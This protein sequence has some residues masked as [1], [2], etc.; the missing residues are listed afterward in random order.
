MNKEKGILVIISGFSGAG[1]GTIVSGLMDNYPEELALSISATT[2][3]PRANEKEGVN[4]FYVTKERFEEMIARDELIEHA[5]F[6]D[7]FYG[8]PK[9]YVE[10]QMGNNK[11]VILEIEMQGALQIKQKLPQVCLIF[12]STPNAE[13]LKKRLTERN[14]ESQE[15]IAKRLAQANQDATYIPEYDYLVVND[16]LNQAIADVYSIIRARCE[17]TEKTVQKFEVSKN[18]DFIN[19]ITEE[20]KGFLKGEN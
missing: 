13:V 8:T 4:Y 16:D 5:Q 1:K 14:T 20:L 17:G 2:R 6:V 12:V 9:A 18:Q 15:V 10:E 11:S 19:K 3:A 7:H